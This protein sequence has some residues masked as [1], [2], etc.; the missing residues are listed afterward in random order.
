MQFYYYAFQ[1]CL[2]YI[3]SLSLTLLR[4]I[5]LLESVFDISTGITECE[6]IRSEASSNFFVVVI[7]DLA[8]SDLTA[9]GATSFEDIE[10]I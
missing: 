10:R 7:S 8:T 6:D 2:D 1:L 4:G 9:A 3:R 5:S